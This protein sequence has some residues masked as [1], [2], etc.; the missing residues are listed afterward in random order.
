MF[1]DNDSVFNS[2]M[3]PQ[4]NIHKR[5]VALSF[6]RVRE[7]IAAKIISYHFISGK[8]NPVDILSKHWDHHCVWPT[9]KTLLSWKGYTMECLDKNALE[10]EE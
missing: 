8:M 3:N 10:F 7:A 2:S 4:G 1:G 5:N 9:L 6:H